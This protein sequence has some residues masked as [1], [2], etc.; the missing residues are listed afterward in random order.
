MGE[1]PDGPGL[2]PACS[3]SFYKTKSLELFLL[4]A[5]YFMMR[6]MAQ[7]TKLIVVIM[8]LPSGG[9]G[10]KKFKCGIMKAWTQW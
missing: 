5:Q 10:D 3:T 9:P 1:N 2:I 4:I 6:A 7:L 8:V